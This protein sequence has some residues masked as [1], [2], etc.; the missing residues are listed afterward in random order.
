MT[1]FVGEHHEKKLSSWYGFAPCRAPPYTCGRSCGCDWFDDDEEMDDADGWLANCEEEVVVEFCVAWF[2]TALAPNIFP[3]ELAA[4]VA[5]TA[6]AAA[7]VGVP[8][9][10]NP[11]E[12]ESTDMWMNVEWS[13][14]KIGKEIN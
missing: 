4:G 6:D 3:P 10:P 14:E 5:A 8:E 7:A 13:G 2:C 9:L 1:L 12:E 11:K